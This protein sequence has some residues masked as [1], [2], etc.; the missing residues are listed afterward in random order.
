MTL[1]LVKGSKRSRRSHVNIPS[2]SGGEQGTAFRDVVTTSL[3]CA[4]LSD[5]RF[6]VWVHPKFQ[7]QNR[8]KPLVKGLQDALGGSMVVISG[9]I[10]FKSPNMGYHYNSPT[11]NPTSNYPHEPPSKAEAPRMLFLLL[12]SPSLGVSEN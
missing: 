2:T 11:Y 8:R 10:S 9:V 6:R 4:A 3:G 7:T 1:G 5:L 12:D